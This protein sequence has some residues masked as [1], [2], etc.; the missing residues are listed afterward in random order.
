MDS[1]AV[2]YQPG[3]LTLLVFSDDNAMR[4]G[5]VVER[6]SKHLGYAYSVE[7]EAGTFW[8]FDVREVS[9]LAG[10][11]QDINEAVYARLCALAQ[12]ITVKFASRNKFIE[13]IAPVSLRL[14]TAGTAPQS[15]AAC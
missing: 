14:M 1:M 10:A 15:G 5:T 9:E 6:G 13:A 7:V 3:E 11:L 8:A 12:F 4:L 2:I